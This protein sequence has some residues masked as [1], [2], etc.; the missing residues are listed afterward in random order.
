MRTFGDTD[1]PLGHDEVAIPFIFVPDGHAGPRPGYPWFEAGRMTLGVERP[2]AGALS[3]ERAQQS[4]GNTRRDVASGERW[5]DAS[6]AV[7]PPGSGYGGVP[8]GGTGATSWPA[9]DDP[10]SDEPARARSYGDS[11]A[12]AVRAAI[13]ALDALSN[14]GLGLAALDAAS[15]RSAAAKFASADPVRNVSE[16]YQVAELDRPGVQ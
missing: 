11:S 3:G 16:P 15:Q 13:E 2:E 4:E 9:D 8:A 12:V 14:P 7:D 1:I 5:A 6:A 10:F